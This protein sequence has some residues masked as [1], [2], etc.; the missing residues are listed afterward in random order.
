MLQIGLLR[1]NAIKRN[2]PY[3]LSTES[4][5]GTG[6]KGFFMNNKIV[7]EKWLPIPGYE[8]K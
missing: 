8:G 2:C 1:I 5:P 3:C 4:K 6:D 7:K